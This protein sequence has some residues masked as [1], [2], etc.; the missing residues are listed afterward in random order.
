MP[1][2]PVFP[3]VEIVRVHNEIH[4]KMVS[5]NQYDH[6]VPTKSGSYVRTVLGRWAIPLGQSGGGGRRW[7]ETKKSC[8]PELLNSDAELHKRHTFGT[9]IE[10]PH[11]HTPLDN[12]VETLPTLPNRRPRVRW[13]GIV[14]SGGIILEAVS[15]NFDIQSGGLG[16]EVEESS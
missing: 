2:A 15:T 7:F 11:T 3:R 16:L 10:Q 8:K 12:Y 13:N 4:E 5:T 14:K 9:R 1:P 6:M